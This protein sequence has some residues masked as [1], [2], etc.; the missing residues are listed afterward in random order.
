MRIWLLNGRPSRLPAAAWAL[1]L[2]LSGVGITAAL[3][4]AALVLELSVLLVS[5]LLVLAV[6]AVLI[7]GALALGRKYSTSTALLA[8]DT[9]G[10]LYYYYIDAADRLPYRRGLA[11]LWRTEQEARHRL[12]A[13]WEREL[14]DALQED[15]ALTG[16]YPEVVSLLSLREVRHGTYAVCMLRLSDRQYRRTLFLPR[17]MPY[18]ADLL[19]ALE[20]RWDRAAQSPE[21]P[22]QNPLPLLLSGAAVL[23]L[24]AVTV[25]SHPAVGRLPDTLYFPLLAVTSL[26]VILLLCLLLR[27]H[28]GEE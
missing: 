15:G 22:A 2:T 18:R 14:P 24:V 10:H 28:R 23:L 6:T 4:V 9:G 13:L 27:R 25:L 16:R 12:A 11:G 8:R 19:H 1:L 17:E 5:L 3:S 21:L 26:A 7:A 20:A